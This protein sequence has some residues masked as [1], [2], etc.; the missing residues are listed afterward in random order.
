MLRSQQRTSVRD[1]PPRSPLPRLLQRR[2]GVRTDG[3]P[4]RP[5]ADQG[6]GAPS[7]LCTAAEVGVSA[8][9]TVV[10]APGAE[11]NM[12]SE[13][14]FDCVCIVDL[15]LSWSVLGVPGSHVH[16]LMR[17]CN[18]YAQPAALQHDRGPG[19]GSCS[20]GVGGRLTEGLAAG[21]S[22]CWSAALGD[23]VDMWDLGS[24]VRRRVIEPL[25]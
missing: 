21:E 4:R 23:D 19:R 25:S 12:T 10:P 15:A 6:D 22:D 20:R 13:C 5:D 9:S 16:V 17:C 2:H 14:A 11:L 1:G 3:A 24:R 7:G 8:D 18:M